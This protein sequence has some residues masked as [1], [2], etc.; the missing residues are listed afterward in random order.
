VSISALLQDVVDVLPLA[1]LFLLTLVLHE[2]GHR[3]AASK[4]G[5]SLYLPLIVPAGFGFLGSFGGI[6]RFKVQ[7]GWLS[8]WVRE[9]LLVV[10]TA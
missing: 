4:R 2:L 3:V 1:G 10:N 7:P 8:V 9:D 6:T 5:V